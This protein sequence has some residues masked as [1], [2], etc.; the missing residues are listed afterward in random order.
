MHKPST[1][2]HVP[3]SQ[4][5]AP[6]PPGLSSQAPHTL[7]RVAHW[8]G[9]ELTPAPGPPSPSPRLPQAGAVLAPEVWRPTR[10]HTA[11]ALRPMCVSAV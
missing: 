1:V 3:L 5:P 11:L 7:G 4:S 10:K 6:D 9:L 2:L 8:L